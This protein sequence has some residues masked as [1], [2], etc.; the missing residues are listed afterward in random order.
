MLHLRDRNMFL[1]FYSFCFYK[2][3]ELLCR[4]HHANGDDDDDDSDHW[5]CEYFSMLFSSGSK[6]MKLEK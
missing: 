1:F 6:E 3:G 4:Q 2:I 5:E